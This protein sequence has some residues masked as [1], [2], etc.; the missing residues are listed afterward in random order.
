MM[1]K[2]RVYVDNSNVYAEGCRVSA[3]SKR[4]QGITNIID[5]M[6]NG[7]TDYGWHLDYVELYKVIQE[8]SQLPIEFAKLWGSPPPNDPFWQYLKTQKFDV[9]IFEKNIAGREKKVDPAITH[10]ITK[11]AYSGVID[12]KEDVIILLAGDTD[13]VPVTEDLVLE[14]YTFIV[15][16]WDHAGM[17]LKTKAPKFVSLNQYFERLTKILS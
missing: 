1:G 8:V 10:Q 13:Y 4:F 5:A 16:F 12:K 2:A 14:G 6:N 7:I 9:T 11:D 15:L 3:V 17:E